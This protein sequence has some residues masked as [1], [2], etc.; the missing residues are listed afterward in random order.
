MGFWTKVIKNFIKNNFEIEIKDAPE[1]NENIEADSSFKSANSDNSAIGGTQNAGS[2]PKEKLALSL[3]QNEAAIRDIFDKCFDFVVREINIGNNPAYRARVMYLA[4]MIPKNI[5]EENVINFLTSSPA[6]GSPVPGTIEYAMS[7]LGTGFDDTIDEI[8]KVSDVITEGNAIVILDGITIALATPLKEPP[9]RNINEPE[10]EKVI[11][12]P[13]EGFIETLAINTALIRKKI[14]SINL[15]M[16]LF[17]VGKETRTDVVICYMKNIADTKIV[18]EV[19]TRIGNIKIDSVLDSNYIAE[20]IQDDPINIIPTIFRTEK[21]DV[22]AGKILEGRVAILVDGSP[23]A[24]TVPSIFP[25]LMMSSEDYY[26]NP[27]LVSVIRWMRYLALFTSLTLPGLY[28]SLITFHSELMP[29]K[30]VTTVLRSRAAVPF[31]AFIEASL[32][33]ITFNILQEADIRI[34]KSM[35]QAVSVVG[36]LVLGQAAVSAGIVSPPMV[37]VAAFAGISGLAVPEPE[38][39]LALIHLR[40]VILAASG[41]LGLLGTTCAFLTIL[42]YLTS[43]RSFGTPFMMPISPLNFKALGDVFVRIPIWMMKHRPSFINWGGGK[44]RK[45][46]Q[47]E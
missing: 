19:R 27:I 23:I 33:I 14:K 25:E 36:A 40:L 12:G 17:K 41:F 42:V 15:K 24:L 21:P 4:N 6:E 47:E 13:R 44:R 16:E 1:D 11:R 18:E 31:N 8:S 28:V 37:I 7:L 3:D 20:Y 26:Q 34:P 10:G 45:G 22:V 46:R 29:S 39:Q 9:G 38:M 30:L 35:G 32:M 2:L 5:I 43:Q